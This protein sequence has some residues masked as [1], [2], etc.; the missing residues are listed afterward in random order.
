MSVARDRDKNED[1]VKVW[2][3]GIMAC[4]LIFA[5]AFAIVGFCNWLEIKSSKI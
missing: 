5:E 3:K 2:A 4:I 1:I